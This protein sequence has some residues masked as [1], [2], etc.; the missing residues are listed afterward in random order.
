MFRIPYA[1]VY[2]Y[3]YVYVC[4]CS[5]VRACVR[6]CACSHNI[7]NNSIFFNN[8]NLKAKNAARLELSFDVRKKL[9][10]LKRQIS[11]KIGIPVKKIVLY[12]EGQVLAFL[13]SIRFSSHLILLWSVIIII[14]N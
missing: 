3:V 14:I 11:E 5:S 4:V 10:V 6:A 9:R 12:K 1:Y 2:V 8:P 7:N 13:E